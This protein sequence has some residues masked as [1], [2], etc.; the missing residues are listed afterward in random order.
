MTSFLRKQCSLLKEV[1]LTC[2]KYCQR[3]TGPGVLLIELTV[4]MKTSNT[5]PGVNCAE[6]CNPQATFPVFSCP[7]A[8]HARYG[9]VLGGTGSVWS[10][11]G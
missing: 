4:E 11:T 5:R 9:L 10:G 6:V 7:G 2:Q 3:H 1:Y 8:V